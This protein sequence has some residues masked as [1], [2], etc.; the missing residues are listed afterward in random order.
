MNST[1]QWTAY[2]SGN[3]GL[4]NNDIW[5]LLSDGKGGIWAGT[6]GGGV[7]HMDSEG[8]WTVFNASNTGL[9]NNEVLGLSSD[10][11]SGI[12][13]GTSS[14]LGHLTFSNKENIISDIDDQSAQEEIITGK[15]LAILVHARGTSTDPNQLSAIKYMASY[16]YHVLNIRGYDNNE[17]N[18]ISYT[19]AIDFNMDGL[20]DVNIVDGPV[21][22]QEQAS[23]ETPRDITEDDI[24]AAFN[25]AK[26]KGPMD[27]PLIFI[28]IDHGKANGLL[29]DSVNSLSGASLASM[30]EDYQ[31]ATG[32]KV[33]IILEACHSGTLADELAG[34]ERV[35]ITSTG[36]SYAY[37][38]EG[39]Q[40]SFIRWY[41]NKLKTGMD[42]NT[43]FLKIKEDMKEDMGMPFNEQEPGLDD[44]GDGMT[45]SQ[46]DGVLSGEICL[47][48]CWSSLAGEVS[49]APITEPQS[50]NSGDAINLSVRI[51]VSSGGL[52]RIWATVMTPEAAMNR[53]Q[54]GFSKTQA[55]VVPL[56]KSG[57]NIYSGSF[58]DFKYRGTYTVTFM[59]ED[60]D[61]FINDS[62]PIKITCVDGLEYVNPESSGK[63]PII[64][65]TSY[66]VGDLLKVTLP[67]IDVSRDA[68]VGLTIP[69]F[70]DIFIL[71]DLNQGV[72]FTGVLEKWQGQKTVL[73]LELPEGL[74][75]GKY[76]VYLLT[77]PKGIDPLADQTV[78]EIGM[79]SF[80]IL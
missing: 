13:I 78:W 10:G 16:A 42:L 35:V 56:T 59:A 45:N 67:L 4:Q 20:P 46:T 73:D 62:L 26:D 77:V 74:P 32:N 50:V 36:E 53:D 22:F 30:V 37:Y 12:W 43:S 72:F 75:A 55:P 40:A 60:N 2:N 9:P 21:T 38:D 15:R 19:P 49:L 48:G 3:S 23:G 57:E 6:W 51:D 14:G 29:L 28:F 58:S 8:K 69:G 1:G 11:K 63:N 71:T 17:I 79:S 7:S 25:W 66:S 70:S 39:G 24:R 47:N 18:F 54:Y 61:G 41:L 5:A 68:F 31:E 52:N 76:T 27:Q 80:N 64:P 34:P 65:E 44:N 33:V